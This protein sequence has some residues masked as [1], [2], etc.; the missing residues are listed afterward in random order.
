[1][2]FALLQLVCIAGYLD[3]HFVLFRMSVKT[4]NKNHYCRCPSLVKREYLS[5]PPDLSV[6]MWLRFYCTL[7]N[8]LAN[9]FGNRHLAVF[10][11]FVNASIVTVIII[12][13]F[14]YT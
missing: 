3:K 10:L 6:L 9:C 14:F 11:F 1:M 7:M 13:F 2:I 4:R 8:L 5:L 12:F